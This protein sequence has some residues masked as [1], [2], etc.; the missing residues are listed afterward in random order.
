MRR[1][2]CGIRHGYTV[3]AIPMTVATRA[4]R[5]ATFLS[6]GLTAAAAGQSEASRSAGT[7]DGPTVPAV[8]PTPYTQ[9]AEKSGR[10]HYLRHCQICHGFDGR[11]LENIDFEATD[12]TDPERW[13][14][15]TTDGDLF[16]STKFGAGLDM[17]PFEAELDD[18]EIWELVHY[19]RSIGPEEYRAAAEPENPQ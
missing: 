11:A 13:R 7:A 15:G 12:L 16:R 19:L 18:T 14:F 4:L 17:P 2:P 10:T 6:L 5:L 3:R 9:A 8:N 1:R